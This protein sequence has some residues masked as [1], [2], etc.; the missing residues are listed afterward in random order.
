MALKEPEIY[1]PSSVGGPPLTPCGEGLQERVCTLSIVNLDSQLKPQNFVLK[2]W[3]T[4]PWLD[5]GGCSS[6]YATLP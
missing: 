3:K 2:A 1:V 6:Q 5:L 4:E